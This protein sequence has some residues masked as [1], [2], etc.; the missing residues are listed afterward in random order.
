MT[1]KQHKIWED[2]KT[3]VSASINLLESSTHYP[4]E[5]AHYPTEIETKLITWLKAS[6]KALELLY[7]ELK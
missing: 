4:T 7:K 3:G 5:I 2:A 1:R 6:E